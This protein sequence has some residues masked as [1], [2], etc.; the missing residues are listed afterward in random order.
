MKNSLKII[1][2]SII[3]AFFSCSNEP[4][5]ES[6]ISEQSVLNKSIANKSKSANFPAILSL[7]NGFYPE[8]IALGNGN[9][10]YAGSLYHGGI[11]K[12]DLRTGSG[13]MLVPEQLESGRIASGLDF[14]PRTNY[15]FAA[16]G[17]DGHVYVYD[18]LSGAEVGAFQLTT[19]VL[20]M[21]LSLQRMQLTSQI[22]L[23]LNSIN[24]HWVVMVVFLLPVL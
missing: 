9:D 19:Q 8:G 14:D 3:M 18:A 15:I 16:G 20:S 13:A 7:P 10:L 2:L 5:I 1:S 17:P 23:Q 24:Y 21:M 22:L 11:Y 4:L 6:E 12:V